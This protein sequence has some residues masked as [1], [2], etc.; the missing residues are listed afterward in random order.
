MADQKKLTRAEQKALRPIQILDA[1]FEEFVKCG[2]AGTRIEDIAD[3]VG[4]TKGT[5]YVYFETKEQL[6]EAMINHFSVPF[7]ELLG[8][9]GAF[10]GKAADRLMAILS[11]LYEQIAED[12]TTR[13]LVRL[14]IAEGQR[15]P[16]LIDRH[17][18]EFIAPII[19]KIDALL[20]EGMASGEF[21]EIPV[22][23]SEI[24]VAP[25]LTTT[26]LRL[27]FDDRRVPTPNKEAFLRTYF[28]LLFNGLL[29][30][31]H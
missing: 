13:E 1:A 24:V 15:F 16:E 30:K 5:V 29:A 12:R 23:F 25:I 11:L 31:P 7:Q 27:I 14:V 2:F 10:S 4:V 3:R 6:F 20:L 22:E 9:V 26:V 28:D 21:R 8:I 18:D 19:A 17:H